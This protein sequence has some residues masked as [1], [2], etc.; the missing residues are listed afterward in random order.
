M[1]KKEWSSSFMTIMIIST[2][3][4]PT[5]GIIVGIQGIL[6]VWGNRKQG[7]ILLIIGSTLT[8]IYISLFFLFFF[9]KQI[10]KSLLF[11]K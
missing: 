7:K 2:L 5:V 11:I 1:L 9:D 4:M 3:V 6:K 10:V 8:V